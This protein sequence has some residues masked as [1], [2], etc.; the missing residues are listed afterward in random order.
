MYLRVTNF[1]ALKPKAFSISNFCTLILEAIESN[2]SSMIDLG[3]RFFE[4]NRTMLE[5][6]IYKRGDKEIV[7]ITRMLM[8]G[9]GQKRKRDE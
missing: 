4:K 1:V 8:F 7:S 9:R 3:K 2:N 5:S 6:Q